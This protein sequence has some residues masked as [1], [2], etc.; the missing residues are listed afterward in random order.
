M[1]ASKKRPR[2][3]RTSR[4][5]L[6]SPEATGG[7]TAGKGFDFQTRYA[8]CHLP[9]WLLEGSFHQLFFEGTGDIDIRF[10]DQGKSSR[11]HI[12][13][14]D[15][16]VSPSEFKS[17][18]E[19]FRDLDSSLP[20][21]YKHFTLACPSLSATLR[22]IE[23][24]LARLRGATPFYDDAPGA[25][26]PTKQDLD[27]R[28]HKRNLGDLIDFIHAKV[29]IDVG[30]GDLCHDD[31][32][33]ELFI[34]RLLDHPEYA[35]KLRSMVQ[36]AFSEIMRAIAASKG[37][38]LDRAA[39]DGILRSAV[40]TGVNGEK[41]ITLWIQNW[42]KESL[43]PPADYALDWSSRFDRASRRVPS[44]QVWNAELLPELSSLQ[45][46]MVAERTERFI[47]FRG[48]CALSTGIAMGT[49]FPAVGGWVFEIPQPPSKDDWRSDAPATSPYE[50]RVEVID[51]I[52]D[53]TDVVL[54][55]N[56]K[57]DGRGDVMRYVESTG[58]R[59][60][61][62]SFFSPPSQGAQSIGGAGDACAFSRGVRDHLGQL[63]KAHQL[64]RTRIFFYGPFAL[65]VFLGQQLTSVGELQ[66]FE[67]QDPGY[68]PSCSLR[69]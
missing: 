35:G 12:Q 66:L 48:K 50:L 19:H 18:I 53:G 47:R 45:K 49:V 13:V 52:A 59:P 44:Q 62:F 22:P 14:K 60:R 5:S 34:A 9:L 38:V 58:N 55:L 26:A 24:G 61:I 54:G 2:K 32:A 39:I 7:I 33:V 25:L 42:T 20:E 63:L 6:L 3:L 69:T 51:G 11:N 68:I 37:V 1:T 67:Y 15:H 56:I 21:V 65:A 10:K 17:V 40:A 36:P 23:T 31:R 4:G 8:A 28:L 46:K 29:F 27:E 41:S 16:E 43:I 30:H 64:V 57:G